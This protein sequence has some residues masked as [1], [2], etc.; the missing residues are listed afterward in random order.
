MKRVVLLIMLPLILW[1]QPDFFGY[2]E[3][4]A[5]IIQLG[6]Q[7]YTFGYN[8]FRLDIESRPSDNV[9]IGA[10]INAQKYWGKTT[11]NIFDFIPGYSNSGME[12]NYAL[13]DSMILD[14]V[15]VKLSFPL[16]DLTLGR[17]QISPGVGYAWNP[18]DIFNH[19]S[20]M[21]PSYEQTGVEVIRMDI[22]ITSRTSFGAIIQPEETFKSS[23]QQYTLSSGVGGIDFAL[24]ASYQKQQDMSSTILGSP[25]IEE[26]RL[27]GASLIGELF[28]WGI[29]TEFAQNIL[30]ESV[31]V[32]SSSLV[33]PDI[34]YSELV[35]GV[36]HTFDNSIY[37]LGEFLHNGFGIEKQEDLSLLDYFPALGGETHSLMQDYGFFYIMHPTFDYVSLSA[38]SIANFNDNSG[39]IAPQ[40]DWNV[41]EDTNLS[42]QSSFSWGDEDTEFGLQDWG[43]R[44]RLRSAF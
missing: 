27:Y 36:D 17:Q 34:D 9:L 23:T 3:S 12:V 37:F 14:N 30:E 40:I 16:I 4:E 20:L 19:K 1:S 39:T 44:L 5:D 13:P 7:R 32:Y 43:L 18:I 28:E 24:S 35:L 6:D 38:L 31:P 15:Y 10:N 26:R 11:W 25:Y 33:A 22:P 41:F 8:K 29:W 42:I 2:F 21:D